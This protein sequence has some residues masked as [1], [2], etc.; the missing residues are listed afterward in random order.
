MT[1]CELKVL[2]RN[3]ETLEAVR[4]AADGEQSTAGSGF[5]KDGVI[6]QQWTPPGW[7]TD[8][9]T[10]EQLV[11]PSLSRTVLEVAHQI[12][13]VGHLGKTKTADRVRQRFYWPSLF[14]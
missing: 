1:N 13:L 10:V 9:M 8:A 6:H 2:Q 12:A 14:M 4:R 5:F 11:L 3:N 7:D